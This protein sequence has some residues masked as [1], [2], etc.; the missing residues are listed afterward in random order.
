MFDRIKSSEN[1]RV[2]SAIAQIAQRRGQHMPVAVIQL[3]DSDAELVAEQDVDVSQI[4]ELVGLEAFHASGRTDD[5]VPAAQAKLDASNEDFLLVIGANTTGAATLA[6]L[7]VLA[8][9]TQD[10]QRYGGVLI[11]TRRPPYEIAGQVMAT[12]GGGIDR[13]IL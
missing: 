9:V 8:D 11:L 3:A 13:V 10:D 5:V 6:E 4:A 12:I 7:V 1:A 2:I